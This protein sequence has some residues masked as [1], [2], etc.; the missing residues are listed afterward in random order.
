MKCLFPL[1]LLKS[2]LN[3]LL[4]YFLFLSFNID[5]IKPEA[6]S[7]CSE[8]LA[9]S[10]PHGEI[11]WGTLRNKKD[12]CSQQRKCLR[13]TVPLISQILNSVVPSVILLL[14]TL[15]LNL[16]VLNSENQLSKDDVHALLC[17]TG[18][19]HKYQHDVSLEIVFIYNSCAISSF[20]VFVLVA[21]C[22]L[23]NLCCYLSNAQVCGG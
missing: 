10:P 16:L 14:G 13:V 1:C 7:T 11:W 17:E 23:C 18:T 6:M 15:I 9:S 5:F 8:I 3:P 2:F 20:S 22:I 21:T 19:Y 12:Q 4:S